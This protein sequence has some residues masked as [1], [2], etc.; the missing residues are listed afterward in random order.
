MIDDL[1]SPPSKLLDFLRLLRAPNVF[2]AFADV[3]M[4]YL[5]VHGAFDNVPAFAGLA[6]ASCSMYLAGMVLNDVFDIE[7]DRLERPSRPLPSGRISLGFAR[8]LGLSMLVAGVAVAWLVGY[9]AEETLA[10][11]RPGAV[12]TALAV[13]ILAYDGGLKKTLFSPVVMG[14]CRFLNVLLGMSLLPELRE[15]VGY[16]TPE[17][18]TAAGIGVYITGVTLFAKRE[19]EESRRAPLVAALAV[20][21]AGIGFLATGPS[22]E[23][24]LIVNQLWLLILAM[25]SITLARR[26]MSAVIT[27]EPKLVQ[28]AVKVSILSLIPLNAAVCAA[29]ADSA[30]AIGV[31]LLLLPAFALGRWVYST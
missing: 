21:F 6:A 8:T 25:V 17:L 30:Y 11:W 31:A 20:M 27:P 2:T 26:C 4:G 13:A 24:A 28:M 15:T 1:A 12:A 9:L 14:L 5:F 23:P 22:L 19:A 10:S 3:A 18:V 29:R 7:I 16:T